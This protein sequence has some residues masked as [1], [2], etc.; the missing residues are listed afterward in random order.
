[1]VADFWTMPHP[2]VRLERVTV[3]GNARGL[4]CPILEAKDSTFRLNRSVGAGPWIGYLE[5]CLFESNLGDGLGLPYGTYIS[6]GDVP[7]GDFHRFARMVSIFDPGS[8]AGRANGYRIF[9]LWIQTDL[10]IAFYRL[11]VAGNPFDK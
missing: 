2:R 6:W 10:P 7:D 1:V 11:S 3:D 9:A 4:I 5:G 8:L